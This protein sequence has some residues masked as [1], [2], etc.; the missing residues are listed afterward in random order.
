MI[1]VSKKVSEKIVGVCKYAYMD[2]T[3]FGS[4]E[5][6]YLNQEHS[7][8]LRIGKTLVEDKAMLYVIVQNWMNFQWNIETMFFARNSNDILKYLGG[9]R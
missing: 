4:E 1:A 6:I 2:S 8:M 3:A 9:R 7:K 5:T